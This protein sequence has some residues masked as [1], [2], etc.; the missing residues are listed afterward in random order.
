MVDQANPGT[1][2]DNL[3]TAL[4]DHLQQIMNPWSLIRSFIRGMQDM[5]GS[6]SHVQGNTT[7]KH[8]RCA[9]KLTDHGAERDISIARQQGCCCLRH[10]A[11]A[12]IWKI[13]GQEIASA[14]E[15]AMG[16]RTRRQASLPTGYSRIPSRSVSTMN[17]T[18]ARPTNA[19]IN[20]VSARNT[21]SSRW[22]AN[23]SQRLR[24]LFVVCNSEVVSAG[25]MLT[26]LAY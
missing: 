24:S 12:S 22:E 5:E 9:G 6:R 7:G 15:P 14:S 18:T 19:P 10:T 8:R 25:E 20:S 2:A 23:K 16:I 26:P 3:A 21:Y 13:A 17:A 1:T 11:A 4:L